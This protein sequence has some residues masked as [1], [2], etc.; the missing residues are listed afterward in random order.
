MRVKAHYLLAVATIATAILPAEGNLAVIDLDDA[1]VG[2][3]N[4]MGVA[5]EIG[6]HLVGT[7]E[8]WLRI[9]DPFDAASTREMAVNGPMRRTGITV[10][11][12]SWPRPSS[13]WCDTS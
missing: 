6:E 10:A 4:T 13:F 1:A 8:R 3:R 11:P 12:V 7:A 9:N 5:A 2:D